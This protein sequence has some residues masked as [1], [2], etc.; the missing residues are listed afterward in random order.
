MWISIHMSTK[1][2]VWQKCYPAYIPVVL[3]PIWPRNWRINKHLSPMSK[4]S[5]QE[6]LTITHLTTV[7]K[8]KTV[9][10]IG[11]PQEPVARV[12]STNST[13]NILQEISSMLGP[14]AKLPYRKGND[15]YDWL[16]RNH[17]PV[18]ARW[19]AGGTDT[20]VISSFSQR[21]TR[22]LPESCMFL[23]QNFCP[24]PWKCH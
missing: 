24:F 7:T 8:S 1:K 23:T 9:I 5:F 12:I 17:K 4:N 10:T 3:C 13:G 21:V 15:N 19:Y 18:L 2:C 16:S 11:C 6:V 14:N 22:C 20:N